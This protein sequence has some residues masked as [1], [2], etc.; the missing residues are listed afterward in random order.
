MGY[1]YRRNLKNPRLGSY[2]MAL[3]LKRDLKLQESYQ[4]IPHKAPRSHGEAII[5]Q[6][7]LCHNYPDSVP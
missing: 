6:G 2:A 7:S 4:E 1:G 5:L 3:S